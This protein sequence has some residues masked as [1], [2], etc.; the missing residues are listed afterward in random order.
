MANCLS[1]INETQPTE[2]FTNNTYNASLTL[3]ANALYLLNNQFA[4][5]VNF[6]GT[7]IPI[8]NGTDV[9]ATITIYDKSTLLPK[10]SSNVNNMNFNV[11]FTLPIGS[12]YICIRTLAVPSNLS[13]N[14]QFKS[15]LNLV[16]FTPSSYFGY[17]FNSDFNIVKNNNHSGNCTQ[18]LKYEL[19]DGSLP[20][21][22]TMN[23]DG[24]INGKLPMLDCDQYNKNLPSS[25]LWYQK[26]E[27]D[28]YTTAYGR[29]YR[30]KVKLSMISDPTKYDIRWYYIS[31][32]TDFSKNI[33]KVAD[34]GFEPSENGAF[35][36]NALT[37][38][39]I[40]DGLCSP[41]S[42]TN[43]NTTA[44]TTDSTSNQNNDTEQST[45]S[46]SSSSNNTYYTPLS[47]S[48]KA[49]VTGASKEF[50]NKVIDNK[51]LD[52][53]FDNIYTT[54]DT[55]HGYI[56]EVDTD[57][58]LLD[59]TGLS[60]SKEGTLDI[61]NTVSGNKEVEISTYYYNNFNDEDN[62]L[63]VRLKNSPIF[64]QYLYENNGVKKTIIE[65]LRSSYNYSSVTLVYSK[66][67]GLNYIIMTAINGDIV[68]ENK[69]GI[70]DTYKDIYDSEYNKL[71]LLVTSPYGWN[72]DCSLYL[73]G[74]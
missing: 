56:N 18:A 11:S 10:G 43:G 5:S 51:S 45:A 72:T 63:I 13:V 74:K 48:P 61:T 2:I 64:Q 38:D 28:S 33:S 19:I 70:I 32:I 65:S 31:I 8:I 50:Y 69:S 7:I 35:F 26:L 44:N 15:Y 3:K 53:T 55:T 36:D 14:P 71:P 58:I 67:D 49:I 52:N 25:N 30:F 9:N 12:Y 39:N 6:I 40:A 57:M 62:L 73:K 47:P 27:G 22:L 42:T 37:I 1:T 23:Q 60:I 66:M 29:L 4:Q 41:C 17:T 34:I 20:I 16:T 46:D 68:N 24:Y 21:G 54:T 59:D